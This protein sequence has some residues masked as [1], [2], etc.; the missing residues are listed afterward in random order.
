M[1]ANIGKILST[2]FFGIYQLISALTL[3][4]QTRPIV[5][6]VL[7]AILSTNALIGALEPEKERT[8]AYNRHKHSLSTPFERELA[9]DICMKNNPEITNY[10]ANT[11]YEDAFKHCN[12]STEFITF[13]ANT[14]IKIHPN[15]RKFK[16]NLNDNYQ[17]T[18]A[19]KKVEKQC[20][21]HIE[22]DYH[23]Q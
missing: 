16:S 6:A 19:L 23:N 4:F 9:Q 3:Y 13:I 17:C 10:H 14:Y 5:S 15:T 21:T 18:N 20:R 2:V 11:L 7:I 12:L 22:K 8:E 1:L